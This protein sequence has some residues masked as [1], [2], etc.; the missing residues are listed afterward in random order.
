MIHG[1]G[2]LGSRGL[3][4]GEGAA[5]ENASMKQQKSWCECECQSGYVYGGRQRRVVPK[6]AS[7]KAKQ[8]KAKAN[9]ST[10]HPKP[11]KPSTNHLG[12]VT[13]TSQQ[14]MLACLPRS[15]IGRKYKDRGSLEPKKKYRYLEVTR[16]SCLRPNDFLRPLHHMYP[17]VPPTKEIL[18]STELVRILFPLHGVQLHQ[19]W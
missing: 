15:T 16:T 11:T 10:P 4:E 19:D 14:D 8:G 13:P 18:I 2:F 12:M 6:Q 1:A 5:E 17:R 9:T 7:K 3:G